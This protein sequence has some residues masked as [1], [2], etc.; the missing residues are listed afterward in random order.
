MKLSE[1]QTRKIHIDKQLKQVGW[2]KKYIKEEVN[3]VKSNFKDKDYVLQKS[4]SDNSGRFA[5][6]LL[7]AEDNSPLAIV[8]AKR[9]S[10]SRDKARAQARTYQNDIYTQTK[11]RI[12]AFLTN[13]NNWLFID[14]DGVERNVSG[15]FSQSDL[16]RRH[17]SYRNRTSPSKIKI[18]K[19]ITD[20]LKSILI[21]KQI[22]E[23][24]EKGHRS[25]LISMATGTGKT[26]V[27]MSII[28]VLIRSNVIRNV[29]FVADRIAL[30]D[31]AKSAGF[32]Q[33]FNEAVVDLRTHPTSFPNGLYV[34][35]IQTLKS[36]K[37]KKVYEKFSPGFFDLIIYD[38]AHRSIY[39]PNRLIHNYFDAIEIGLTATPAEGEDRNTFDLFNCKVGKPTAEY[40]Y[41]EAIRDGILVPYLVEMIDTKVLSLGIEGSKLSKTLKT[42]LIKQEED[43]KHSNF[44]GAQFAK[45]FMDPKT[46]ELIVREFM[47]RCKKSD[48]GKPAK[49]I[50]FC[51]NKEHAK[52]LKKMFNKVI[53]QWSNDVQIITSDIYRSQDEINRFKLDSSPRIALSVGMLD[54]GIDIPEVCNIVFVKPVFSKILFWQMLGRGTRNE[55]SAKNKSWLPNRKKKNFLILDFNVGN[56]SNTEYHHLERQKEQKVSNDV[57]TRIFLT[58]V[59]LLNNDLTQNQRKYIERKIMSDI[60]ALDENSFIVRE[61]LPIIR[62]LKSKKFDLNE[63]MDDLKNEI[64]PLIVLN[65]RNSSV[66]TSFE[67]IVWKLFKYISESREDQIQ[68]TAENIKSKMENILLKRHL[69]EI[70]SKK[71]KIMKVFQDSFWSN[72]SF[73]DVEFILKELAPLMVHYE[74]SPRRIIQVDA[75]DVV[76]RVKNFRKEVKKD[77]KLQKLINS[78]PLLRKLKS[79]QGINTHE[80]TRIELRLQGLRPEITIDNIQGIHHKDF[81]LFLR[82]IVGLTNEHDPKVLIRREFDKHMRAKSGEYT[83]KQLAFIELL[84]E[85]F[86][87]KK[88]IR[89]ENFAQPPLSNERPL[90]G[91]FQINELENLV[92]ICQRIKM[93]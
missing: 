73:E 11:I 13:G 29:L 80:L 63:Y 68:K 61:K 75:P 10:A 24:I 71:T 53:P 3:T 74:K 43:P 48:N 34:T 81:I 79:G 56:H 39:D 60:N 45:V 46:N 88:R 66:V 21:T 28:N 6:Y 17:E 77:K 59:N 26:R 38:E 87:N 64:A 36:G 27:A 8:E 25:A 78:D 57:V 1:A 86:A 51:I 4:S 37:G 49:T 69:D 54:T 20:R 35:T 5:D 2:I 65:P 22:V 58:K 85:V 50:F 44:L 90:D 32:K 30:T 47:N 23:H 92:K 52:N 9:F 82:E 62:K 41:D 72:L 40:T 67:S 70:N 84:K 12:P 31:Q 18:S 91:L 15:P 19:K 7:L 16:K 89:M 33:F 76:L 42:Q 93:R 14:Q 83:S 55:N